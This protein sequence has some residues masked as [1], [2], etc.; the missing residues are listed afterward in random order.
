MRISQFFF[1]IFACTHGAQFPKL[2]RVSILSCIYRLPSPPTLVAFPNCR[3]ILMLLHP[4][5]L[6]YRRLR[7]R[8][9]RRPKGSKNFCN[10]SA[11]VVR[12]YLLQIARL[13]LSTCGKFPPRGQMLTAVSTISPTFCPNFES[14]LLLQGGSPRHQ[15]HSP[16]TVHV[17]IHAVSILNALARRKRIAT[18]SI[19]ANRARTC[20]L[21]AFNPAGKTLA[22]GDAA[23]C[24]L[25]C[26]Q[27]GACTIAPVLL[28]RPFLDS[29][30]SSLTDFCAPCALAAPLRPSDPERAAERHRSKV[31]LSVRSGIRISHQICNL[32]ADT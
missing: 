28:Q 16:D 32:E 17:L 15:P 20:M 6:Q 14:V 19:F 23:P 2:L 10:V 29:L 4:S 1:V 27:I 3:S 25:V 24:A 8:A 9:S 26:A 21:V 13:L 12:R 18:L 31:L 30:A 7:S 22:P 11:T 5:A